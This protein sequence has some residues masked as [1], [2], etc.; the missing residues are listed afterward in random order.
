MEGW[1]I[2][3]EVAN[4]LCK[5]LKQ[6]KERS[7]LEGG[8]QLRAW[9]F[10]KTEKG[11]H[12]VG[13]SWPSWPALGA[14]GSGVISNCLLSS[15]RFWNKWL[16][17]PQED[18]WSDHLTRIRLWFDMVHL[19]SLLTSGFHGPTYEFKVFLVPFNL[20][21]LCVWGHSALES[22][23]LNLNRWT[24]GSSRNLAASWSKKP[25]FWLLK[26]YKVWL[27]HTVNV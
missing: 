22:R 13:V 9:C 4:I 11:C 15:K 26:I 3:K 24:E 5:T 21:P 16:W 25:Y 17:W 20:F 7:F 23:G 18:V 12:S 8:A 6:C 19:A 2:E 27:K 10:W 1:I 14:Q